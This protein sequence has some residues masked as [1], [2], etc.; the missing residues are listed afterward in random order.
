MKLFTD[1]FRKGDLFKLFLS[2]AFLI[3]LWWIIMILRDVEWVAERT[4][5]TDALGFASYDLL[6]AL[7]EST[8][9][10]IC[11]VILSFLIAKKWSAEK[12]LGIMSALVFTATTWAIIEQVVRVY[13][14][15]KLKPFFQFMS[16]VIPTYWGLM[17]FVWLLVIASIII[18][19]WALIFKEKVLK[20]FLSLFERLN[21]LTSLY[22]FF[23]F[24]AIIIIIIR[25]IPS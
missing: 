8:A 15:T 11:A 12:R 6:Y 1:R 14:G 13:G 2:S 19:V 10:F 23:D 5:A 3:H 17:A 18:P 7:V 21:M 16:G 24:I 25:N 9:V 4:N 22:L 20:G